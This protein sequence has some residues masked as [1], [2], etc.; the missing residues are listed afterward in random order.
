MDDL[1]TYKG[2][3]YTVSM[4]KNQLVIRYTTIEVLCLLL[5]RIA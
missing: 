5:Y 1:T 2:V 4:E 3:F